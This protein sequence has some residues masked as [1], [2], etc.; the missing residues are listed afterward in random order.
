MSFAFFFP[1]GHQC[2][3]Y[4]GVSSEA[5]ANVGGREESRTTAGRDRDPND[6]QSTKADPTT[7]KSSVLCALLLKGQAYRDSTP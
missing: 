4:S 7:S 5:S 1:F 2:N 3:E 6:D